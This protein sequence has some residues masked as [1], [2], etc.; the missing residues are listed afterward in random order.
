MTVTEEFKLA[1]KMGKFKEAL[2]LLV[3]QAFDLTVTTSIKASE[4]IS[5][6]T[7][8]DVV[9]GEINHRVDAA[10]LEHQQRE[11]LEKIHF[12]Q[13]QSASQL[14]V[15]F[16]QNWQYL[17]ELLAT[18]EEVPITAKEVNSFTK[19]QPPSLPQES[20]PQNE[21]SE[22]LEEVQNVE[23]VDSPNGEDDW[24]D[25]ME[26]GNWEEGNNNQHEPEQKDES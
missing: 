14:V 20:T 12:A 19:A 11:V 3:G 22:L 8:I 7:Q 4:Q 24:G 17:S 2:L 1:I 15:Q 18:W 13:V 10:F 5:I 25:W 26:D 21:W 9:A 6:E 23:I 16:I